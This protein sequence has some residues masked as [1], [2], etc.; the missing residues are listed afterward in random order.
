MFGGM[1][2]H[3]QAVVRAH[4]S[5]RARDLGAAGTPSSVSVYRLS[6]FAEKLDAI[7]VRGHRSD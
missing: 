6:V 3:G 4:G 2:H 1:T 5:A 7:V